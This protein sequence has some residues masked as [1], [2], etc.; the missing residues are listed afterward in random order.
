MP[1]DSDGFPAVGEADDDMMAEEAW[2]QPDVE[3]FEE[4]W[5]HHD[6]EMQGEA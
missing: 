3:M 4:A 6:A 5:L 2:S 1:D